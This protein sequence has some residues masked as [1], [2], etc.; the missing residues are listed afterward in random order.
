MGDFSSDNADKIGRTCI[1]LEVVSWAGYVYLRQVSKWRTPLIRETELSLR[2][3]A[4]LL[5]SCCLLDSTGYWP[6]TVCPCALRHCLGFRT[7]DFK[8]V[9]CR[10]SACDEAPWSSLAFLWVK[11]WWRLSK[12]GNQACFCLQLTISVLLPKSCCGGL[13]FAMLLLPPFGDFAALVRLRSRHRVRRAQCWSQH[14]NVYDTPK[15][16]WYLQTSVWKATIWQHCNVMLHVA[17]AHLSEAA[18][19]HLCEQREPRQHRSCHSSKSQKSWMIM[20]SA[21]WSGGCKSAP[22]RCQASTHVRPHSPWRSHAL[23][24]PLAACCWCVVKLSVQHIV[25]ANYQNIMSFLHR[26]I[27][28][29]GQHTQQRRMN[30]C[31]CGQSPASTWWPSLGT[32]ERETFV[33]SVWPEGW[34]SPLVLLCNYLSQTKPGVLTCQ[35]FVIVCSQSQCSN[36][37]S[38]ESRMCIHHSSASRFLEPMKLNAKWAHWW[39][40]DIHNPC[41]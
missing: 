29:N 2:I 17:L 3:L 38:T 22:A 36:Q 13:F 35:E 18:R 21:A 31:R 14:V 15:S 25:Q 39:A 8:E 30:Q 9:S 26:K 41:H 12:C 40:L 37:S 10:Q 19:D 4:V 28:W 20:S 16:S 34:D 7:S 27:S 6:A 23:F 32:Q 33:L 5:W 11:A 1:T 24:S